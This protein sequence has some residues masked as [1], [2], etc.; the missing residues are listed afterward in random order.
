VRDHTCANRKRCT[1][2]A[3][4]CHARRDTGLCDHGNPAVCWRRHTPDDPALGTPLCL[5]CYDHEHHV[6]WNAFS[7]ELWHRTKQAAERYLFKLCKARGLSPVLTVT[8]GGKPK[9]KPPVQLTHGKVAEL[10][11]RAVVHFHAE[12]RLDG[13]HPTDP[14]AVITPP[15]GIGLDDIADA[16]RHAV[17]TIAFTTPPHPDRPEGWEIRWGDVGKGF[18]IDTF[19]LAS[20]DTIT[21]ATVAEHIA[22]R[23]A[24]YLAK[25]ATKSTEETGF[26]STRITADT[27]DDYADPDGDHHARLIEACWRL[28]RPTHTPAPLAGRPARHPEP[29]DRRTPFD[30][31]W[32]C[33]DC[34]TRT[35]YAACPRC[36]AERQASLDTKPANT[37]TPNP[38]ARLCRY[39]H[40]FGFNGHFLTKTRRR[41]VRFQTL[42]DERI[43]FRRTEEQTDSAT[44]RAADHAEETTLIVG[45]LT[46]A[47]VGWHSSG[48]ALLANSAAAQARERQATGREEL[49]HEIANANKAV[50]QLAA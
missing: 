40:R 5:D 14:E 27:I 47:G 22:S 45:T 6:V 30:T 3:E 17:A 10:Q 42:R 15:P 50:V 19:T 26:S 4:P 44:I 41:V 1:C 2:R 7:T 35:R 43:N 31:P 23:R 48:D 37:A 16:F 24:G 29:G 39:A 46:F 13:V 18:D 20:D 38:Y 12:I 28:G 49:A 8:G 36:A 32:D 34:G 33:L 21:D 9:T 11:R 25:Y